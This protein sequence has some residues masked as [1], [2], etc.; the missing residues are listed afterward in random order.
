LM[1]KNE[2][3]ILPQ[4]LPTALYRFRVSLF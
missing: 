2:E 1:P 4:S 3:K